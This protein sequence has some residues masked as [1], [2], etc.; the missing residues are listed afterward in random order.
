MRRSSDDEEFLVPVRPRGR[1]EGAAVVQVI[2]PTPKRAGARL[3]LVTATSGSRFSAGRNGG[4]LRV[5]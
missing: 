1:C 4:L 5:R 2:H 3:R